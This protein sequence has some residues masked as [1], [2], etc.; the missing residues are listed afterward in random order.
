ML[1]GLNVIF[2]AGTVLVNGLANILPIANVETEDISHKYQ[3]L[4]SPADYAFSIWGMIYAL[5]AGFVWYQALKKHEEIAQKCGAWFIVNCIANAL[6]MVL[7]HYELLGLSVACMAVIVLSLTVIIGRLAHLNNTWQEKLFV[8][9]GLGL[10]L[11]WTCV[12]MVA[13]VASFLVQLGFGGWGIAPE[14]WTVTLLVLVA[15]LALAVLE[16]FKNVFFG[17]AVIWGVAG[18][19]VQHLISYQMRYGWALGACG[20]AMLIVLIR[21]WQLLCLEKTAQVQE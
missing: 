17:I 2:F 12:A 10:Y 4:F 18:V 20:L 8:Q 19:M 21:M 3:H 9:A 13:N 7:W 16:K 5:L 14:V 6:W 11:G 15:L 1:R